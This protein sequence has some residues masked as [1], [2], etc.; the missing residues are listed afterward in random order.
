M[1]LLWS[2][3]SFVVSG[4]YAYLA[5]NVL[6][7]LSFALL[8]RFARQLKTPTPTHRLTR[9][10][11]LIPSYRDDS[12]IVQTAADALRQTYPR[13]FY[14][15]IVI[16]DSLQPGTL[17]Q[18]A[19]LPIRVISVQF[20]KSTKAKA[21]NVAMQQLPDGYYDAALVLDADNLMAPD[22]LD[23][24]NCWLQAGYR[25]VQGHRIA[26]NS[27]TPIAYLDAISEEINNHLF[28]QGPRTVG[29][30]SALIGSGAAIDYA[31]FKEIMQP[32]DAVGGFDREVEYQLLGRRIRI[33]Y[34]KD[35]YIIDEKVRQTGVFYN[36]RRRWLA[37]QW[38]YTVRYFLPG[39]R[40]LL[41]G[42]IDYVNKT[43][44]SLLLPRVLLLGLLTG[45]A[46]LSLLMPMPPGPGAWLVLFG[47]FVL[48]MLLAF[49]RAYYTPKLLMSILH[50]PVVFWLMFRL[51]FRI[52]GANRTFIHTPHE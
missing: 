27:E 22:A 26:K 43:G 52:K 15:V 51:L 30:S 37:A 5:F 28:R 24:L 40:E 18:L 14:D 17:A 10:A 34:A 7:Q 1:A 8:G 33:A 4:L 36:Q 2:V 31:L 3:V 47:G 48:T 39:M 20:E 19:A 16:A 21:L 9:F 49:P 42:N 41:R 25:A 50:V 29:L 46:G 45:L 32:I 23:R 12:V 35:A 38:T 11:V 13:D 6:Y 44:Q